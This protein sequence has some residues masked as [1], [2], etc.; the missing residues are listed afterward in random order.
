M[1]KK[2]FT[3]LLPGKV[4]NNRLNI[5]AQLEAAN[6]T[7]DS[8]EPVLELV[9]AKV[10]GAIESVLAPDELRKLRDEATVSLFKELTKARQDL[11]EA[12]A[13]A[14][15]LAPAKKEDGA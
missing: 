1:K 9:Q 15:N 2:A 13:A 3:I 11:A 12:V 4:R 6:I 10:T 8:V 5:A 14:A 7:G